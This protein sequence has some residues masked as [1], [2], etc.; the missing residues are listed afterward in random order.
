MGD[1]NITGI[2]DTRKVR[3]L[4]MKTT[5]SGH[6]LTGTSYWRSLQ[7][8]DTLF[9]PLHIRFSWIFRKALNKLNYQ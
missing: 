4:C 7:V 2:S 6:E 9:C 1:S 5:H 3:C 8:A